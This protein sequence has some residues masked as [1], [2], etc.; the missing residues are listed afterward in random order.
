MVNPLSWFWPTEGKKLK[1]QAYNGSEVKGQA[2][3]KETVLK[4]IKKGWAASKERGRKMVST[5]RVFFMLIRRSKQ[6]RTLCLMLFMLVPKIVLMQYVFSYAAIWS[7]ALMAKQLN[8][9]A[10]GMHLILMN[11]MAKVVGTINQV[12]MSHL[13]CKVPEGVRLNIKKYLENKENL[14][15]LQERE[16]QVGQGMKSFNGVGDVPIEQTVSGEIEPFL[17]LFLGLHAV[18][19]MLFFWVCKALIELSV[20]G[21]LTQG[22]MVTGVIVLATVILSRL[23]G[24]RKMAEGARIA[25]SKFYQNLTGIA[26]DSNIRFYPNLLSQAT[27]DLGKYSKK[28]TGNKWWA[29]WYQNLID[30][31]SVMIREGIEPVMV[32]VVFLSTYLKTSMSY[33]ALSV[34]L[35]AMTQLCSAISFVLM[36]LP[37]VADLNAFTEHLSRLGDDYLSE[38]KATEKITH[39]GLR[40]SGSCEFAVPKK[41][42]NGNV[43][44]V[45]AELTIAAQVEHIKEK[46][47]RKYSYKG[48]ALEI[49]DGKLT[50]VFGKNGAGKSLLFNTISGLIPGIDRDERIK[51]NACFSVYC[52]QN[53][54]QL[55]PR[56]GSID[57]WSPMQI[58]ALWWPQRND[59]LSIEGI[60]EEKDGLMYTNSDGQAQK[61][62]FSKLKD[63]M[64]EYLKKLGFEILDGQG[65][66]VTTVDDLKGSKINFDH[67]SGGQKK[68]FRLALFLAMAKEIQPRVFLIDEPY[69]DL[70][71]DATEQFKKLISKIKKD[72]KKDSKEFKKTS[73]FI[74]THSDNNE[75]DLERYDQVLFL[76]AESLDEE[77][78]NV[79]FYGSVKDYKNWSKDSL[80]EAKYVKEENVYYPMAK[81]TA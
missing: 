67:M 3:S 77:D 33:N 68:K 21:L 50:A 52:M 27:D 78:S 24:Y 20:I 61:V 37:E 60:D 69:N 66:K 22:M 58:M 35:S 70:D 46:P 38:N 80:G 54:T 32:L 28:I 17:E 2:Q 13:K 11:L 15:F 63:I 76:S 18:F 64:N 41:K 4:K 44:K 81:K 75:N 31:L 65:K 73:T 16:F 62:S 53:Y 74:V 12:L 57:P 9:F 40:S 23:T 25:E 26:K 49:E 72:D 5:Y 48:K 42:T 36:F 55:I 47:F 8:L 59:G 29:S 51:N 34:N 43:L 6:W 7:Q 19:G 1:E 56:E 71:F 79:G 30:M 10:V 39:H 45:A 14:A